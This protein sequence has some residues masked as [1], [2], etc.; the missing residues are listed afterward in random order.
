MFKPKIA[1]TVTAASAES[2]SER[3]ARKVVKRS[4]V[5]L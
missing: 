5:K 2:R 1:P 3:D 4:K